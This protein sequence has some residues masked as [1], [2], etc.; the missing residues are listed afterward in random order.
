VRLTQQGA[1]HFLV[2]QSHS[3]SGLVK[4]HSFS[5]EDTEIMQAVF[6]RLASP[7]LYVPPLCPPPPEPQKRTSGR[8]V[9]SALP[10]CSPPLALLSIARII[11]H[12]LCCVQC[13]L[14]SLCAG[15][16][17]GGG[18]RCGGAVGVCTW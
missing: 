4:T 8:V 13:V 6:D 12:V 2:F 1:A 15:A 10:L 18:G 17:G 9:P 3:Q 14:P 16:G 5:F 11:S 7:N